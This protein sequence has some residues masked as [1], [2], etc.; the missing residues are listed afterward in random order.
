[1]TSR[2][3]T[4]T[5]I[6]DHALR[7]SVLQKKSEK[8]MKSQ[9]SERA[10]S[11]NKSLMRSTNVQDI[12]LNLKRDRS[13]EAIKRNNFISNKVIK[14]KMGLRPQINKQ[15]FVPKRIVNVYH[16]RDPPSSI[17]QDSLIRKVTENKANSPFS[18]ATELIKSIS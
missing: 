1:M 14:S 9:T 2:P 12:W 10:G 17:Y 6:F 8:M 13:H 18:S 11:V 3:Q 16:A 7:V 4:A 15:P 5:D